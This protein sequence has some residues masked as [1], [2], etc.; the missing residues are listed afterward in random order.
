[1]NTI[2]LDK[3]DIPFGWQL[4]TLTPAEMGQ[5]CEAAD[6]GDIEEADRIVGQ[7]YKRLFGE[8]KQ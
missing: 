1:M 8:F 5:L 4:V 3:D 7:A 6:R 2:D